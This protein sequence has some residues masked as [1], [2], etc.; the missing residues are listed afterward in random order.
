[1]INLSAF[2]ESK[3][4]NPSF[5]PRFKFFHWTAAL[6]G[7]IGC[8]VAMVK[9]NETYALIAL[10]ITALIYFYLRKRDIQTSYGDAKRGYIFQNTKDNLFYLDKMKPHPKNWRPILSVLTQD[11]VGDAGLIRAASWLESR[12][13]LLTIAQIVER[14]EEDFAGKMQLRTALG[15]ELRRQLESDDILAF[16]EALVVNEMVEGLQTFLQSYS[17]GGLRPNTL[18]VGMP[19]STDASAN[20]RFWKYLDLLA[21]CDSSLVVYKPGDI[22]LGKKKRVIDLWWR[23]EK[24]GSL[25]ALFAYLITLDRSWAGAQLRILRIVRDDDEERAARQHLAALKESIRIEA[26]LKV[27]RTADSPVD[28]I[29]SESGPVAD[30]V[31]LG[32]AASSG[33]EVQRYF[34]NIDSLLSRLPTTFM[35]WSNGEADVFA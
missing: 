26:Q 10:A 33:E 27:L 17:I 9:I 13:G 24:N 21:T 15:K 35:I 34:A 20:T 2:V 5:R 29:A 25:M 19:H 31:L 30:L 3:S 22:S 6:A 14:P 11:P 23:G 4:S 16:S 1:M 32:M 7:A 28:V 12:R 8:F 18:V